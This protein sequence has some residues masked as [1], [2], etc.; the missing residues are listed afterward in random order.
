MNRAIR[1]D[2]ML[3]VT[4]ELFL[5]T[6]AAM[7]FSDLLARKASLLD[8]GCGNGA[9]AAGLVGLYS[10][11]EATGIEIDAGMYSEALS[12][13]RERLHFM[14]GSYENWGGQPPADIILARLVVLHLPDRMAFVRWASEHVSPGGHVVVIDYDDSCFQENEALPLFMDL[15]RHTRRRMN[16]KRTF[17]TL[18]DAL[19]I[20]F[21]AAG[22]RH[23][24][25]ERYS[26]C[27]E[28]P[29][30]KQK[31]AEYMKLATEYMLDAPIGSDR[32]RELALWL[33]KPD[34]QVEIP[35]FG[36]RFA[37]KGGRLS[38]MGNKL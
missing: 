14:S 32:E 23:E 15:Y 24:R 26:L 3:E 27:A 16:R 20:E 2:R 22:M 31:L 6:E 13:Q 11:L 38:G 36:C 8:V 10:Q 37:D 34:A 7:F 19:R 17:L 25:T 28:R 35:M 12:R 9:Y 30:Q 4:A 1:L 33:D 5:K 29:E 21:A 18:P